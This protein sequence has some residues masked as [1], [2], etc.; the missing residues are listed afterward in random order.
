MDEAALERLERLERRLRHWGL[1]LVPI[2]VVALVDLALGQP[3][4][5]SRIDV[6]LLVAA[7]AGVYSVYSLH[8][9][10]G[11]IRGGRGGEQPTTITW[12]KLAA[13]LLIG[14][15]CVAGF[16]YL[17]GGWTTAI[18]MATFVAISTAASLVVGLMLRRRRVGAGH[19]R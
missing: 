13:S 7:A 17:L 2:V 10:V 15:A 19:P 12:I 8:R 4:D 5:D 16:G 1:L 6:A 9:A 11:R 14:L 3:I 18:V